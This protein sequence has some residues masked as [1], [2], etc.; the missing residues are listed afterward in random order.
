LLT[1]DGGANLPYF[2]KKIY[3]KA[4]FPQEL[5]IRVIRAFPVL[6][7]IQRGKTELILGLFALRVR[8]LTHGVS[9]TIGK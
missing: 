5:K 6:S 9:S 2:G 8:T 1:I 4:H 3:L 7:S